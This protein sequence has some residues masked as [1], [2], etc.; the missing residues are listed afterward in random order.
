[1]SRILIVLSA[2]S[3]WTRADGSKCDS[4]VWAEEFVV[5]HEMFVRAGCDVDMATP[6]GTTPTIDPHGRIRRWSV[7]NRRIS[8][9]TIDSVA[10]LLSEAL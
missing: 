1:M 8:S 5:M 6:G 10:P 4:G 2:A 7:Q 9:E 3:T